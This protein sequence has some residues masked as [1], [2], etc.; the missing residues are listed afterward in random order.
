MKHKTVINGNRKDSITQKIMKMI[1]QICEYL[2]RKV[3]RRKNKET[4]Y[5]QEFYPEDKK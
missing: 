3:L 2:A 1:D 5:N 4:L